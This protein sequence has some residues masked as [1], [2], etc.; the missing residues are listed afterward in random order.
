MHDAFA[1]SKWK[2]CKAIDVIDGREC[3]P[4]MGVYDGIPRGQC[5]RCGMWLETPSLREPNNGNVDQPRN[6]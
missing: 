2:P 1:L 5:S 3:T 6:T 4:A